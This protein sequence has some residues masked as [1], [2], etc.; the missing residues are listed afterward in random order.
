[1]GLSQPLFLYFQLFFVM[2]LTD[3]QIN[4]LPMMG[5]EPRIPGVGSNRSANCT[6]T[7]A[8]VL[9]IMKSVRCQA[10][11]RYPNQKMKS[12]EHFFEGLWPKN[13]IS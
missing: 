12:L 3:E 10:V 6:T 13:T 1:M 9:K 8:Q 4:Y 7:T 11:V 2:Q 5:L